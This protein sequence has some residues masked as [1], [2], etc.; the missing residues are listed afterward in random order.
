[1]FVPVA[2]TGTWPK[3]NSYYSYEN[4]HYFP[5][6]LPLQSNF[7][8]LSENLLHIFFNFNVEQYWISFG[9]INILALRGTGGIFT[10]PVLIQLLDSQMITEFKNN[11]QNRHLHT[12]GNMYAYFLFCEVVPE[13]RTLIVLD[14]KMSSIKVYALLYSDSETNADK[15]I[16][17]DFYLFFFPRCKSSYKCSKKTQTTLYKILPYISDSWNKVNVLWYRYSK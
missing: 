15:Q 5:S 4:L 1:M 3:D 10:R 6:I 8:D 12:Y 7:R 14:L 13:T 9:I 16:F 11:K 2:K 17:R